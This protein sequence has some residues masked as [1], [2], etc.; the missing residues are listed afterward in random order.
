VK[1]RYRSRSLRFEPLENRQL[2]S[3][4][5]DLDFG[6]A[7]GAGGRGSDDGRAVAA[8]VDGNAYV[9]GSF[10][11]TVDFDPGT[12]TANLTSEGKQDVFVAKYDP[13]GALVWA[14]SFGAGHNDRAYGIAVADDGSVYTTGSF[15]RTVDFDPGPA[16]HMLSSNGGDD[17]FVS[18]LDSDGNF[19]WAR[20]MGGKGS[21]VG[22]DIA[23]D[24]DGNAH[25]T[26]S[27]HKKADFDPGNGTFKLKSAGGTDVFVSKLDA[28]GNF[29]WARS[30]GATRN[31]RGH[32]I[33][34]G[35]DG[36]VYTT[37]SF[38]KTV[39][40][41][42]GPGT[43]ELKSAGSG[44]VFVS[45]LSAEGDFLGTRR[46]GGKGE[47][48]GRDIAVGGDNSVFITG[49]FRKTADFDPGEETHNLTSR[50]K[51]D[52]FVCRLDP[53]GNLAWARQFGGKAK[54]KGFA[55]ALGEDGSVF[56][57][58]SFRRTADFDPG[59]GRFHLAS[60]GKTDVFVSRLD[61]A[62]N[63]G[64]AGRM[65]GAKSDVGYGIAA[66]GDGGVYTT[67]SFRRTADFDPGDGTFNL[68]A[69]HKRDIFV[70]RL[71]CI[72]PPFVCPAPLP[73]SN[74]DTISIVFS[75]QADV[76]AGD[77][78]LSGVNVDD[79]IAGYGLSSF[80]YDSTTFIATWTLADPID[81]DNLLIQLD[82]LPSVEYVLVSGSAWVPAFLDA[83]DAQ[84]LGHPTIPHL[85][86]RLFGAA[87]ADPSGETLYTLGETLEGAGVFL[88]SSTP[89]G[90]FQFGFNVLPA[91]ST[92]STEVDIWDFLDLR[93]SVGAKAGDADYS[94]FTDF[95]GNTEIDL[96]D[97]LILRSYIGEILP[98]DEPVEQAVDEVLNGY[99]P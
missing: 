37:G 49:E 19:L 90:D 15:R 93:A 38:R 99:W 13:T 72:Q 95:D 24:G 84:G 4:V 41:D 34:V 75:E 45:K 18:K 70:T 63:F 43:Y 40:F 64:W 52:A 36:C 35:D 69:A 44:D 48:A 14:R 57:T 60:A 85:G 80:S 68:T 20:H 73:W 25:T 54:D 78:A 81:T 89:G 47:D 53:A 65:G 6:F 39:D 94:V 9:T 82:G 76:E 26:G 22:C 98:A 56:T 61:S 74:I 16:R 79:Y 7:L 91:D 92:L 96:S 21:D 8:D 71:Q 3:V 28:A 67:G 17:I 1:S 11:G 77:L 86:Y 27:F 31:D 50:G 42:P 12:G 51:S 59:P 97:F 32:G 83:L 33:A 5:G 2:L 87:P 46:M 62:G 58:G 88:D 29:V 66:A 23:V 55:I 30:L 10:Q